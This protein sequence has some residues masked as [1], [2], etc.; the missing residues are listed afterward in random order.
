MRKKK[1]ER[2]RRKLEEG[3]RKGIRERGSREEIVRRIRQRNVKWREVEGT[4][5]EEREMFVRGI[6]LRVIGEEVEVGRCTERK[7]EA[8]SW[9]LITEIEGKEEREFILS[10]RKESKYK[11]GVGVD[12][13]LSMEER[14]M[15]WRMVEIARKEREKGKW[16]EVKNRELWVEN[17]RWNW[18]RKSDRWGEE[19]GEGDESEG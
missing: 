6:I 2:I 11:W 10:K 4:D 5:R 8:E 18:D 7:G 15:R 9:V 3:E 17:R 1:E 12:E 16:A 14:R 13:D 19:T